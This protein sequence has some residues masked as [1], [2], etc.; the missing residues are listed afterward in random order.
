MSRAAP[1]SRHAFTLVEVLAAVVVLGIIGAVVLP[2]VFTASTRIASAE[3]DRRSVEQV[4]FAMDRVVRTLREIPLDANRAFV[5]PAAGATE[6]TLDDG[7]RL[8]LDGTTLRYRDADGNE[9]PL[10]TAVDA[11]TLSFLAADGVTDALASDPA[12]T[13]SVHVRLEAQGVTLAAV[14]FPRVRA[15]S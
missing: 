3:S 5:L 1:T 14:A 10:C 13:W 9:A 7:R 11:F 6:I 15:G 8:W 12:D 2:T 4:A